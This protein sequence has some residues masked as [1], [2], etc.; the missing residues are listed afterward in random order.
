[1]SAKIII[2]NIFSIIISIFTAMD[3]DSYHVLGVMS[4]T[5][6]DGLDLCY[7]HFKKKS[8]WCFKIICSDT[9]SYEPQWIDTLQ[10]AIYFDDKELD[11]L[12][13]NYTEF[14][15]DRILEF[16]KDHSI[17]ELDAICSHGHTILHE[18]KKGI[19]KQIGNLPS[20]A[21][22]LKTTVVC[23]FRV[24]D[25]ELGGQGAPLVP[26]GDKLLF[27]EYTYCLN[28]GGFA[29]ISFQKGEERIAFD[30]C[31]VNIILNH[32]AR[33][34][35]VAFDDGGKMARLG[36][37]NEK[38]LYSLNELTYYMKQPPKSL[39]LEWVNT[40]VFPLIDSFKMNKKD[41]LCTLV[42]HMAFQISQ[43][44]DHSSEA[45]VLVTGGGAFN[46]FL[47]ERLKKLT[48]SAIVIPSE[49][50]VNF[51]EALVFGLLGV[52]KIRNEINCLSSVTGAEY[53]H[54]SGKIYEY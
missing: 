41:I 44:I 22:R 21:T 39:G 37:L 18:P 43:Q 49:E 6:L 23:D 52:L 14:L 19:T 17:K 13:E 42:E 28:L 35:G 20:I 16:V 4:G 54:S 12:D 38:L 33:Q 30:I 53:D 5:S 26:I 10:S 15:S 45:K 8:S 36:M 7:V 32:Y 34:L 46:T 25:V 40:H 3:N 11:E 29:N 50:I 24:Q 51:K 48:A 47:I 27:S 1:M 31:P 2:I 9:I